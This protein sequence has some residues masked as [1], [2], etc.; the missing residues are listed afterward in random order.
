MSPLSI[1]PLRKFGSLVSTRD[2][3]DVGAGGL[4]TAINGIPRPTGAIRGPMLYERLW[5]M[6]EDQASVTC[7][8]AGDTFTRNS[9]SLV[10]GAML[11]YTTTGVLPTG[12][13]ANTD[14]YIHS[15]PTANTFKVSAT[16][17]GA[18]ITTS[19]GS[20]TLSYSATITIKALYRN[21]SY[22]RT[23]G[24]VDASADALYIE[25]HNLAVND[26][27]QFTTTGTL[28][29][30]ISLATDY[31]IKTSSTG[32]VTVSATLGGAT[33]NITDAGT[34][35]HTI[36]LSALI[37]SSSTLRSRFKTIAV[38]TWRQGKHFVALYDL[39]NDKARGVFYM[40][41]DGTH[42]GAYGF[43]SGTPSN[44]ILAVGLDSD[45]MWFGSRVAGLLMI[46]NGVD[47]PVA[48]Q[49]DRTKTPGKW[50][51]CA[52]NVVPTT[53]TISLASPANTVNIPASIMVPGYSAFTVV[54]F[55][56]ANTIILPGR[57]IV[58]GTLLSDAGTTGTLPGGM[59]AATSY[60]A[61]DC[62]YDATTNS[63]TCKLSSTDVATSTTAVNLTDAGVG[64][65]RFFDPATF[66]GAE[67]PFSVTL[68]SD[69]AAGSAGNGL[70][71]MTL[72][73]TSSPIAIYSTLSG[74]GTVSDPYHYTVYTGSS[75]NTVPQVIYFINTDSKAVSLL[76]ASAEITSSA[77]LLS[78]GP[79]TFGNGSGSGVSEGF[80]NKTATVYLA[81]FDTGTNGFGYESPSSDLTAELL[82]S[83][84]AQNDVLVTIT[85]DPTAEGGR[86]DKIRVY[87]QFGE[88][89]AAI[90]NLM[91]SVDNTS[92][93][94]TLQIG[95]NTEIGLAIAE[96]DQN[97]PLPHKAIV[98]ASS[99]TWRGGL[100][101]AG[102]KDRL[103]ISK[104]ATDDEKAP[105]GVSLESYEIID[106]PEA[107]APVAIRALF[108]DL[109]KLHV[110]TNQG[111]M[112]IDPANVE[113]TPHRPAVNVGAMN[114]SCFG[115]GP[116]NA[117]IYIGQDA[118][119]YNFN[120]NRYGTRNVKSAAKEAE[121]IIRG[122]T[123]VDAIGQN[124]DLVSSVQDKSGLLWWWFP[125]DTGTIIGVCLD[126]AD[127]G[128]F[129]YF[130]Y[131]KVVS[132]CGL[133]PERPELII[134]DE[135][136]NLFVYDT[137]AQND[138]GADLPVVTTFAPIAT[139][140]TPTAGNNG[141][142]YVDYESQRYLK[143]AWVVLETGHLDLSDMTQF[144]AYMGA[145]LRFVANSRGI[146][147]VTFTGVSS[148]LSI[149]RTFGEIGT[150]S[151]LGP[152]RLMLQIADTAVKMKIEILVAEQKPCVL[153]DVG[154]L[155]R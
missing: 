37:G 136:G 113:N 126:I 22:A 36:T 55:G 14:Y 145:S 103:Y 121:A 50:R 132:S 34:G 87:L 49:L 151:D 65:H 83:A 13:T 82:I 84:T 2:S 115:M 92:G 147:R 48:V 93:T 16:D 10:V 107:T 130:D 1:F 144:R 139:S 119:P 8:V 35:T 131:P 140:I 52:S 6:G 67:S 122:F 102:F 89:A 146:L 30:G 5:A 63:T 148:G 111:V 137:T 20:G 68:Q 51:K 106:V 23:I 80:T 62:T 85:T 128:L 138:S 32:S 135:T 99:R 116:N 153:R 120:G 11:R 75:T 118:Q 112:V 117:I 38:R 155:Y 74:T 28:P 90:W 78:F 72:V 110:H 129:G 86:F 21:L 127:G 4:L 45:A 41:D 24:Y 64:D 58:T 19:G 18:A 47:D 98:A 70:V 27:V 53:P 124:A 33:L 123:N 71:K 61:Y 141:Y 31:Y 3:V 17:G 60:W 91:G 44:E 97:R 95:T 29:A 40:G 7:T 77:P 100:Q 46:Q 73:G 15:I 42:T 134:Q 96:F 101:T 57:K 59:A 154:I 143:A 142:Q 149:I 150:F 114:P 152:K 108:S 39:V 56:A 69:Y 9:H 54:D 88:G 133:E 12:L 76:F 125:D 26:V 104:A 105:E 66:T 43:T 25:A 94:K 79:Y 81:Y 109:F